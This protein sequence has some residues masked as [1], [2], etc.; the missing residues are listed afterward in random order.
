M[1][2]RS[3]K[4][5]NKIKFSSKKSKK[6]KKTKNPLTNFVLILLWSVVFFVGVIFIYSSAVKSKEEEKNAP[7][8]PA[9]AASVNKGELEKAIVKGVN[10]FL[11]YKNG[12]EF[13]LRKPSKSDFDETLFRLG[14]SRQAISKLD[15]RVNK[16]TGAAFWVKTILPFM[17][18]ILI[19]LVFIW[20]ITKQAKGVGMQAFNFG[21][22]KARFIDPNDK[23]QRVTFAD[24]AGAE[25]AKQELIEFVDFLRAPEKY[26]RI[27]AKIPKGIILTGPPGTGKTLLARAVAGEAKV[28]F[29]SISGSE[30]V[31][32]FVGV[33]AS[34]VRDLFQLAKKNSPAI[35]FIDEI[36]AVGRTR[37]SGMGGG[38]DEREQSLNQILVEMD[39][40]EQTDKVIVIAAT[41][42]P[43][44]LDM[45]LLRPG[46]FDRKVVIGNPDIK[47]RK[48]ILTVHARE[49]KLKADVNF[50]VIARRT[51]GLS[52]ADLASVINEA[53]ILAVRRNSAE[54]SQ[55]DLL[56]SIEKVLFGPERK[57][58][59]LTKEERCVTAYHEAGHA[60]LASILPHADPVQKITIV[61]R[62]MAGGYVLSMPD[63]ERK[64]QTK[65]EFIDNITM[66]LGGYVTEE[67]IFGDVSTGPSSDLNQVS[68]LAHSMVT[69]WGMSPAIGP[70]VLRRSQFIGMGSGREIH[71]EDMEK[72]IDSEVNKIVK[73]AYD[74]AKK[75]LKNHKSALKNI[76]DKLLEVET[77]ER[78]E[79]EK[80]L[81]ANGVE[82]KNHHGTK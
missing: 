39:G 23:K 4:I 19:L 37:G 38:N 63:K 11:T 64:I 71:S 25:E 50:E 26:F 16:E 46:R 57:S 73:H 45:A 62:G 32:M 5:L 28:P 10:V 6:K 41:N 80:L 54:I 24:V 49:K 22:S 30:F 55:S 79:Y 17:F 13:T 15:Y 44:V 67:L 35:V 61:S 27:G 82:I 74:R 52:G 70:I 77:L 8:L 21:K 59:I 34:R 76:A 72:L 7:S 20:F 58:H 53:A 81:A 78:D 68:D 65:Q 42:R 66:A 12:D 33:G 60:L 31:E 69:K 75:L 1:R 9:V 51:P 3:K 14:A 40:F 43:D 47:G 56:V 2:D 29:F 36:D 48:D 18:P